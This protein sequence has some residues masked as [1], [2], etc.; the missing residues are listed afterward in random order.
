MIE[1]KRVDELSL[2]FKCFV[3]DES[4]LNIIVSKLGEH[5]EAKGK[6]IVNDEELCKQSNVF[7][8]KLLDFKMEID[9]LLE[10]SFRNNIKFEKGRDSAF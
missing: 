1:N 6:T 5:I 7:T 9:Q 8:K 3:R 10:S 2:M 4:N